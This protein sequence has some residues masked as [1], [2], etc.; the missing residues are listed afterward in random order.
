MIFINEVIKKCLFIQFKCH[1][2][3]RGAGTLR[4]VPQQESGPPGGT[5]PPQGSVAGGQRPLRSAGPLG[6]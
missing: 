1:D 4:S 2:S 3:E 6:P 5:L